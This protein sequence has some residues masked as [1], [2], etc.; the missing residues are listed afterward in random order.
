M[1]VVRVSSGVVSS[2]LTISGADQL[3]VLS[4]GKAEAITLSA[5]G[6]RGWYDEVRLEI[7]GEVI[8]DEVIAE[9]V[10]MSREDRNAELK[11]RALEY[12]ANPN[13]KAAS[14][15]MAVNFAQASA[16]GC[17]PRNLRSP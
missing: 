2:G 7:E 16:P 13:A 8:E 11:R 12:L 3:L 5:G 15:S 4:G 6:V 17:W 1:T 14:S 9:T 10:P